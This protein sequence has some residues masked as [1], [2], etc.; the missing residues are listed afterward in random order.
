MTQISHF[1]R[2]WRRARLKTPLVVTHCETIDFTR[3]VF[4]LFV[5]FF[6]FDPDRMT[7]GQDKKN[8]MR[9]T[10]STGSCPP[11]LIVSVNKQHRKLACYFMVQSLPSEQRGGAVQA[12]TR[13][14]C[15]TLWPLAC[16]TPPALRASGPPLHQWSATK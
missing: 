4:F 9:T 1:T 12:P 6:F 15:S 14:V 11:L 16:R 8:T 3:R 10:H 13:P 5:Y 7:T 2:L